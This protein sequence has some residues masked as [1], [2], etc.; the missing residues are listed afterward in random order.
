MFYLP[1]GDFRL[2][3]VQGLNLSKWFRIRRHERMK[4]DQPA[5]SR[6]AQYP[7]IQETAGI[8]L[9]IIWGLSRDYV[10]NIT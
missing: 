2:S 7:L 10:R 8:I 4:A 3:D 6:R 5:Y 9:G 1:K